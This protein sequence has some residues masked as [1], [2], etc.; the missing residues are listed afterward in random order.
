MCGKLWEATVHRLFIFAASIGLAVF[1]QTYGSEEI[2]HE[3]SV[4]RHRE[5]PAMDQPQSY[6]WGINPSDRTCLKSNAVSLNM[7]YLIWRA[8]EDDLGFALTNSSRSL[9]SNGEIERLGFKWDSGVRIGAD[10]KTPYDGW[11]VLLDWTWYGNLSEKR[12]TAPTGDGNLGI[13]PWWLNPGT[14]RVGLAKAKW[15]LCLNAI[16]IEVARPFLLSNH[17]IIRPFIGTRLGVIHRQFQVY[18][19]AQPGSSGE[20]PGSSKAWNKYWGIGPRFGVATDWRLRWNFYFFGNLATDIL[21]GPSSGI[22]RVKQ[23]VGGETAKVIDP[24]FWRLLNHLQMSTG[25]GWGKCLNKNKVHLDAQIAW[26]VNQ[27]QKVPAF[28]AP[29]GNQL[30]DAVGFSNSNSNRNLDLNGVTLSLFL[31][32]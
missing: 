12:V 22:L 25:F 6:S 7:E 32:F 16:D 14:T 28:M 31:G 11:D 30:G 21:Y 9:Q 3:D 18:Y 24:H 2:A 26:E 27:W 15:H 5:E 1:S 8:E 20:D 29:G 23:E 17:L 19:Q 4:P 10:W 13:D